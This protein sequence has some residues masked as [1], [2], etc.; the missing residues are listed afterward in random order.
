[1]AT[2]MHK[3]EAGV[4]IERL[5]AFDS[6]QQ[7]LWDIQTA[8]RREAVLRSVEAMNNHAAAQKNKRK[9]EYNT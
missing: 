7:R 9:Q 8:P 3:S 5:K 1:M 4:A 6:H 2:Y